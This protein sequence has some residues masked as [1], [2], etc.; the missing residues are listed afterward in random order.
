MYYHCRPLKYVEYGKIYPPPIETLDE[1]FYNCYK[2]LGFY[3]NFFPQVWLSRSTSSI[4]GYKNNRMTK[5]RQSCI[6]GNYL[7][8]KLDNV[9]FGFD[10]IKGFPV[11]YNYWEMM[12]MFIPNQKSDN[13]KEIN[14]KIKNELNIIL[15][16]CKKDGCID[17][18]MLEWEKCNGD[19]DLFLKKNLFVELDQVVVPSL[20]LKSAKQIICRDE[21]QKKTLKRMGFIDDRI[22]IKNIKPRGN[23]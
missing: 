9:M 4:T 10:I 22:I 17:K 20:N 15:D 3:C 6:N 5:K 16:D 8:E 19:F 13:I 21:K 12:L 18:E 23:Y 2:W 11:S 14:N 1:M 7:K